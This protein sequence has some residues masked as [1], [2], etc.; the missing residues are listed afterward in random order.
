MAAKEQTHV[1]GQLVC[2]PCYYGNSYLQWQHLIIHP[3]QIMLSL[4]I[5][6]RLFRVRK[7]RR[8]KH[9]QRSFLSKALIY[10]KWT[11][12]CRVSSSPAAQFP[13][14]ETKSQY[15]MIR[16]N[17]LTTRLH[18]C[19]PSPP[20]FSDCLWTLVREGYAY[21]YWLPPSSLPKPLAEMNKRPWPL[22]WVRDARWIV[23]NQHKAGCS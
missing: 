19:S 1:L 22:F 3:L 2:V 4:W 12:F 5:W 17:C 13:P 11:I 8:E 14:L 20:L 7:R 9:I 15:N 6:S 16:R 21:S 18:C 10:L 23:N